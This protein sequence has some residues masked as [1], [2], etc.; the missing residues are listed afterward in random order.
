MAKRCNA[1]WGPLLVG[2]AVVAAAWPA[3]A[4]RRK[5]SPQLPRSSLRE[6][7]PMP[8][9]PEEEPESAEEKEGPGFLETVSMFFG[10]CVDTVQEWHKELSR[11]MSPMAAWGVLAS[12]LGLVVLLILVARWRRR[13]PRRKG[14]AKA[15]GAPAPGPVANPVAAPAAPAPARPEKQAE[16]EIPPLELSSLQRLLLAPIEDAPSLHETLIVLGSGEGAIRALRK[17]AAATIDDVRWSAAVSSR[18][19]DLLRPLQAQW[20]KELAALRVEGWLA[21]DARVERHGLQVSMP[22]GTEVDD[23]PSLTLTQPSGLGVTLDESQQELLDQ[24]RRALGNVWA[25]AAQPYSLVVAARRARLPELLGEEAVR[26]NVFPLALLL[27]GLDAFSRGG[28]SESSP[29]TLSQEFQH[30][31]KEHRQL[32][33]AA[34]AGEGCAVHALH[35]IGGGRADGIGMLFASVAGAAFSPMA[36]TLRIS[37]IAGNLPP[38]EQEFLSRLGELAASALE[39]PKSGDGAAVLGNLRRLLGQELL[40]AEAKRNDELGRSMR[41]LAKEPLWPSSKVEAPDVALVQLHGAMVAHCRK[42][43]AAAERRMLAV[44][45]KLAYAGQQGENRGIA[46]RRLGYAF[47][48][49]GPALLRSASTEILSAAREAMG[50]LTDQRG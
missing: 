25:N 35:A 7:P 9:A 41:R 21:A 3:E 11:Q 38:V 45:E 15:R 33:D 2:L 26:A 8:L 23:L 29:V 44:L 22:P 48:G 13:R 4:Q 49:I 36:V 18:Q 50:A 46:Y 30:T 42:Q 24:G 10:A 31:L 47:A 28:L 20:V 32:M 5:A 27:H 40:D 34:V 43:A 6:R 12:P 1:L 37:K 39:R 16:E 19:L 17:A 14:R